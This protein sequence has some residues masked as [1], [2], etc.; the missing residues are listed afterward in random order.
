MLA[1]LAWTSLG[2]RLLLQSRDRILIDSSEWMKFISDA[3]VN[4]NQ[5]QRV[6]SVDI[7][8]FWRKKKKTMASVTDSS[9]LFHRLRI[10]QEKS[11]LADF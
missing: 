8:T 5:W 1:E 2:A 10:G 6:L 7:A 3:N 11:R 4:S 9:K